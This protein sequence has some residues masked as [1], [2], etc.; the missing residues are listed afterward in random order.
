MSFDE[1]LIEARAAIEDG[2]YGEAVE[3][4]AAVIA[5]TG[6]PEAIRV[7][8][9]AFEKQGLKAEAAEVFEHLA[10]REPAEARRLLLRAAE[11]H[12]ESGR[13][14]KALALVSQVRRDNPHDSAA[15]A[16]FA[17][18]TGLSARPKSVDD[19]T[20]EMIASD[21]PVKLR[22]AVQRIGD[23]LRDIRNLTLF[24][25]LRRLFPDDPYIR[26]TLCSFARE[27]C[28]YPT[29]EREEAALRAEIARGDL[30][31][32]AAEMPLT[33]LMWCADEALNRL[34]VNVSGLS[35]PPADAGA[36]RHAMAHR[37]GERL[38]IGYLSSDLWDDHATMRLFQSVLTAHD[39]AR[40]DVTLFCHTPERFVGFDRGQRAR[41]G[42]IVRIEHMDDDRAKEAIRAEGIDILVD[43][44][45][46]T[47]RSRSRLM[48]MPIAP[49]HVQWLGFPGSCVNVDCD[50]VI[51]DPIVLPDSSKPHYHEKFCR[52]PESY[53]PN[54]PVHR[55]LPEALSREEAGLPA[56]RFVFAAFNSQRKN[57]PECV[58]LWARVL[59]ASPEAL[60]W[61]MVDGERARAATL[62]QFEKLGVAPDRILFA[63]KMAYPRHM[64]RVQAADLVLDSFP[65][66]GHTTTSD[67]LWAG[68]PVLTKRGTNFAS[69]VSESLLNAIGLPELVARD[70]EDFV[71]LAGALSRDP[72]RIAALE[73]RIVE[74]R[75]VA[76]LF[77]AERFCR[78]LETAFAMMA[79]RAKAGLSPDHLDVPARPPEAVRR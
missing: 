33:N 49:V 46:H 26:A 64:A 12:S 44:K 1:R 36:R 47:G 60:F 8:A 10:G 74:N 58:A 71:A 17:T 75:S 22:Q 72:Q 67:M 28:D 21:D 59:R 70:D 29:L 31:G 69:R 18:L 13:R 54:D 51:G 9:D 62:S 53:Q 23:D 45:G 40:F 20:N 76:P 61:L 16:L 42:R 30:R 6:D 68:L 56:G 41:W 63:P 24:G 52:L 27:F 73:A 7:L 11:L 15:S 77:N 79:E 57:S 5:A 14:D 32:L 37:W 78:H 3:L 38:R 66:N 2:R 55:V 43:L 25:K 34:A 65:Y 35:P 39:P 50:Y 48:N 4:A 19:V